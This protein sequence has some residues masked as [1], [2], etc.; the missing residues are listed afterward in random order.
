MYFVN[1]YDGYKITKVQVYSET[2]KTVLLKRKKGG[3]ER[4]EKKV[5][6][7][8]TH[9]IFDTFE[10]AKDFAQAAIERK[11][12]HYSDRLNAFKKKLSGVHNLDEKDVDGHK[13]YY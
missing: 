13:L 10:D 1:I 7:T 9:V 6:D 4:E 12:N 8:T 11:I 2:K 3:G 5:K